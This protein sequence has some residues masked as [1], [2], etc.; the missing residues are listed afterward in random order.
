[1]TL[2]SGA[3]TQAP[4]QSIT[5]RLLGLES[6][7]TWS[8]IATLF[9]DLDGDEL[10]GKALWSLLEPLGIKPEAMRVALHRLKKDGWIVSKKAGREVIYSLSEH[11]R[12]E[13]RAA[14]IDVYRQDVKFAEGWRLVKLAP[15]GETVGEPHIALDKGLFLIP[16]A[17]AIPEDALEL[18]LTHNIPTWV[19]ELLVP[20]H[21]RAQAAVLGEL[22]N[23]FLPGRPRSDAVTARLML[24]HYW[25]KM[26]LRTGTWAHIGLMP[27]GA[28]AQCHSAITKV[29][30]ETERTK[31]IL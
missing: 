20:H 21:L 14:Q 19:E 26:A 11:A 22:A 24:L 5:D 9:G 7:K 27:D 4:D 8:L 18:T 17:R 2:L 30:R 16:S 25:R 6:T 13:T 10:S 31:P 15:D 23:G 3:M 28:M 12:A 1:M 29:L